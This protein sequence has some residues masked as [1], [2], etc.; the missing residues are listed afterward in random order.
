MVGNVYYIEEKRKRWVHIATFE[1]KT[2]AFWFVTNVVSRKNLRVVSTLP[3]RKILEEIRGSD[4]VPCVHGY[5]LGTPK[6]DMHK[7]CTRVG[8][9]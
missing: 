5:H 4:D 2:H 3:R 6:G 9:V 1:S 7:A 8:E